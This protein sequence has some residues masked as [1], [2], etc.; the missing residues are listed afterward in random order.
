M[1]NPNSEEEIDS[2]SIPKSEELRA[3]RRFSDPSH[4][5]S[6][7][8]KTEKWR[9]SVCD[10]VNSES[11]AQCALCETNSDYPS[12]ATAEIGESA[13]AIA[14]SMPSSSLIA[15]LRET[16]DSVSER[17]LTLAKTDEE[18]TGFLDD[19]G[20]PSAAL[21][22]FLASITSAGIIFADDNSTTPIP[23]PD[24]ASLEE[25]FRG[26]LFSKSEEKQ[27]VIPQSPPHLARI[28]FEA[29]PPSPQRQSCPQSMEEPWEMPPDLTATETPTKHF[30][31]DDDN[32]SVESTSPAQRLLRLL[33]CCVVGLVLFLS[34][35]LVQ[36]RDQDNGRGAPGIRV[37]PSPTVTTAPATTQPTLRPTS[38]P[39]PSTFSPT[40]IVPEQ[41]TTVDFVPETTFQGTIEGA[42]LGTGVAMDRS[43]SFL[44]SLGG[45]GNIKFYEVSSAGWTF[46]STVFS[47]DDVNHMD[48]IVVD[49]T[50]ILA[51]ASRLSVQVLQY[52]NGDWISL[53]TLEWTAEDIT[54][55][56]VALSSSGKGLAMASLEN[57]GDNWHVQVWEWTDSWIHKGDAVVYY[58]TTNPFLALSLDLSGDATVF[59]IGDWSIANPAVTVQTYKWN[60]QEW[61]PKGSMSNFIWG[62]SDVALTDD[63]N[64]F[65]VA[66]P[67]PGTA[68]V[69]HWNEALQDWDIL[70]TDL[71]GGSSIDLSENGRRVMV[72]SPLTS[73]VVVYDLSSDEQWEASTLLSG[74]I[75]DQYGA[76][77]VMAGDGNTLAVGSP[78]NDEGGRNAGKL[79]V[80]T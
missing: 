9:C 36:D 6:S 2:S 77:I 70:G 32:E 16:A 60:G 43:G 25:I 22:P 59:A 53:G 10:Y 13:E 69:Y 42:R 75:G 66:T 73:T 54:A 44:A 21:H 56:T 20:E 4:S 18:T 71:I 55:P 8:P 51:M 24:D 65:A 45:G 27:E 40:T 38:S 58:T 48:M 19:L 30:V 28:G 76:S 46:V 74:E 29:L 64:C 35:W 23:A 72:G 17:L 26:T 50:P 12:T 7:S 63:G 33:V 15:S 61:I 14:S 57:G 80:Y 34:I 41:P 37:T 31:K 49:G 62:P 5:T 78:L 1:S 47:P 67:T 11:I 79:L 39:S 52:L 68:R 3:Q